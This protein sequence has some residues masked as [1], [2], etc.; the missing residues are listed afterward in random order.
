MRERPKRPGAEFINAC[1]DRRPGSRRV[2]R[3]E[4]KE[5]VEPGDE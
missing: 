5:L 1:S 2:Y 3:F 4:V